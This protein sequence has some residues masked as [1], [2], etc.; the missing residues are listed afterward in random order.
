MRNPRF[1]PYAENNEKVYSRI[2]FYMV[3][4]EEYNLLMGIIHDEFD[5]DEALDVLRCWYS[6]MNEDKTNGT[7][8]LRTYEVEIF[9]EF[10]GAFDFN[11]ADVIEF[12]DEDEEEEE[13]PEW[14]E[15]VRRH[16]RQCEKVACLS[17]NKDVNRQ[18][19][20]TMIEGNVLAGGR[21]CDC[22]CEK[23]V[24]ASFDDEFGFVYI[25]DPIHDTIYR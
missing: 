9:N 8:L 20:S 3:R 17:I 11:L 16:N 22:L 24:D 7:P 25:H 10:L 19:I 21:L 2:G 6:E 12:D 18:C 15:D 23:N 4:L 1:A 5:V 14:M 13:E